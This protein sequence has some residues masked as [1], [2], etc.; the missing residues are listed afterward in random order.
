MFVLADPDY[1]EAYVQFSQGAAAIGAAVGGEPPNNGNLESLYCMWN[2]FPRIKQNELY[3]L[4][5]SSTYK[6][7]RLQSS[8]ARTWHIGREGVCFF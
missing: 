2:F 7:A 1:E 5:Q 4:K 6:T 8:F 3:P